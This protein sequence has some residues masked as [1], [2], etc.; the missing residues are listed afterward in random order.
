LVGLTTLTESW[1]PSIDRDACASKATGTRKAGGTGGNGGDGEAWSFGAASFQSCC[2]PLA[3]SVDAGANTAARHR[4]PA[5]EKLHERGLPGPGLHPSLM[6]VS[7]T[8]YVA[9]GLTDRSLKLFGRKPV[10][11]GVVSRSNTLRPVAQ[12]AA[13][14]TTCKRT[15]WL[16]P[17]VCIGARLPPAIAKGL[18]QNLSGVL[19]DCWAAAAGHLRT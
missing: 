5:A 7:R 11:D 3:R 8:P 9:P 18:S 12:S 15:V 19:L 10:D 4:S 13:V 17:P 1:L 14:E 6:S 2:T 16:F